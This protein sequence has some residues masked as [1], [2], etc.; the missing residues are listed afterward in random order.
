VGLAIYARHCLSLAGRSRVGA[1][2]EDEVRRVLAPCRR[3]AGGCGIPCPGRGG[4][5]STRWRSPRPALRSQ[6]RRRPGP[7][8]HVTSPVC[9][10]RRRGCCGAGEDG[11][12][13]ALAVLCLVRMRGVERL[14]HDVLVVSIDRLI[15]LLRVAAGMRPDTRAA[16]WS[17][18]RRPRG[19]TN[20]SRPARRAPATPGARSH[21]TPQPAPTLESKHGRMQSGCNVASMCTAP[22]LFSGLTPRGVADRGRSRRSPQCDRGRQRWP[23]CLRA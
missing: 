5:T 15:P 14:E 10:S 11:L 1:R 2:S 8:T 13:G 18:R 20:R 12:A 6:S 19:T 22:H 7:T 21:G 9:T 4:E 23:T 16:P 17:S 3:R